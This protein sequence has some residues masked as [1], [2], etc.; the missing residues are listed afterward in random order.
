MAQS[1]DA[2]LP[3]LE[4]RTIVGLLSEF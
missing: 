1:P 2:L 3:G 4:L